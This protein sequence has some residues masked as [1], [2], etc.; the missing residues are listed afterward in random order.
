MKNKISKIEQRS[1]L[2]KGVVAGVYE[3]PSV[4]REETGRRITVRYKGLSVDQT[5][6]IFV[7]SD[8]S[9]QEARE[10]WCK[11]NGRVLV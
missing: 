3:L 11:R 7:S 6:E 2:G 8:I 1:V 9:D 5:A 4:K 10:R